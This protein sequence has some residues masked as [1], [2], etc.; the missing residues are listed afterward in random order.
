VGDVERDV[1]EA[2][3]AAQH[4]T[5]WREMLHCRLAARGLAGFR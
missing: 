1:A 5:L 2:A 3:F 4:Q